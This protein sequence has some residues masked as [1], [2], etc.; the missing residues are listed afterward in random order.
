MSETKLGT[1]IPCGGQF[2]IDPA[3]RYSIFS[4]EHFTDD[5][6]AIGKTARNFMEKEIIPYIEQLEKKDYD[7]LIASFKTGGELGLYMTGIPEQWG[8]LGLPRTVTSLVN[9][10]L[11]MYGTFSVTYGA[12]ATIGTLPIVYFGNAEQK[13]RYLPRLATGELIGAYALSEPGSGSDALGARTTAVLNDAGTHYVV[14]GTKQWITN[15]AFADVYVVFMQIANDDGHHFSALIVDRDTPGF[16]PGAEEH[17]LGIRGSS[18]TQLIFEDALVP[19]ENLLGEIGR[20]HEIAFNILNVGRLSLAVGVTGGA[21]TIL[22]AAIEY[23]SERK[24]F[25]T[26]VIEFGALRQKVAEV[27]AQIYAME[28]ASYRGAGLIDKLSQSIGPL[29]EEATGKQK[30]GPIEEYATEC[31]ICKVYCSDGLN[32]IASECLQMYGGYG[33]VEDYPA[34]LAF[35]DA[36]INMIFEGT[37]EI[38]RLLIPGMIL[39]RAMKG[40]LDLMPWM[41][42]LEDGPNAPPDGP[43]AQE[44]DA[45]QRIKGTAG[46]LLQTAAMK[47]MQD[48]EN[49]QQI[50]L[51]LSNLVIES[52]VLDSVVARSRQRHVDNNVDTSVSDSMTRFLVAQAAEGVETTKRQLV[53]AMT[54][55]DEA[56]ALLATLQPWQCD[57]RTN[58][59]RERNII[60]DS[61]VQAGGYNLSAF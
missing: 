18:T 39:K 38:N 48:L 49:Q 58:I 46:L 19:V 47:Y 17:K 30:M 14:N 54:E 43:L 27:V 41:K 11:A 2:L 33:Y 8:G 61:V 24:Q 16:S 23:A 5:E 42:G 59:V 55:G 37:N 3:G 20:G 35:R 4:P 25:N 32:D 31:A 15:G 52:Y 10:S 45:V 34:E 50:L 6:V 44:L 57:L 36:R 22:T 1:T 26:P 21:K 53:F 40:R 28:T 13:E 60:A 9:E 51:M 56:D 7:Q 29:D 12:H